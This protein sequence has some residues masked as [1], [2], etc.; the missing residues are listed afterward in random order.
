[1]T[2]IGGTIERPL[3]DDPWYA[4]D[5][6]RPRNEAGRLP[7]VGYGA[8]GQSNRTTVPSWAAALDRD[9]SADRDCSPRQVREPS[10]PGP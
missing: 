5:P 6:A 1:M 3:D 8:A 7:T 9:A 4:G 2:P 10:G